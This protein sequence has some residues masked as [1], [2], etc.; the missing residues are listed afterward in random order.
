MKKILSFVLVLVFTIQ[1]IG[2]SDNSIANNQKTTDD[3]SV[4]QGTKQEPHSNYIPPQPFKVQN[5]DEAKRVI[6]EKDYY[7]Q[8]I[9][10]NIPST[11]ITP[12]EEAAYTHMIQVITEHGFLPLP[13]CYEEHAG[14][15]TFFPE[16]RYEDVGIKSSCSCNG[17]KVDYFIYF[18]KDEYSDAETVKQY[19]A[20]RFGE[21]SREQA[22]IEEITDGSDTIFAATYEMGTRKCLSY[23]YGD[24]EISIRGDSDTDF[25]W[26]KDCIGYAQVPV[27]ND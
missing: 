16:A 5:L 27:T 2:C 17:E 13:K 14:T 12:E 18:L 8:V 25:D 21:Q 1:I 4:E 10:S 23:L 20:K 22:V 9:L 3:I 11:S 26:V 19:W 24:V 6:I 15:I 7:K